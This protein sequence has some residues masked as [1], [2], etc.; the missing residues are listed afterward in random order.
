[1]V[2]SICLAAFFFSFSYVLFSKRKKQLAQFFRESYNA[3]INNGL[4]AQS[5]PSPGLH[6]ATLKKLPDV[7]LNSVEAEIHADYEK[8]EN[9]H[10]DL[11]KVHSDNLLVHRYYGAIEYDGKIY[12]VKTTMHEFRGNQSNKAYAYEVTKIEL[13]DVPA[14]SENTESRPVDFSSTNSIS[15]AKVLKGVEKSYDN[16]KKLLAESKSLSHGEEFF[17]EDGDTPISSDTLEAKTAAIDTL[18]KEMNLQEDITV[19]T[20]TEGLTGKRATAQG[21]YDQRPG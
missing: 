19:L 7:I 18:S 10:R 21:W 11:N 3:F 12:R 17:R 15:L 1:M 20:S 14:T 13:V 16:G 9:G 2:K 6:L 4:K 5:A 8:D